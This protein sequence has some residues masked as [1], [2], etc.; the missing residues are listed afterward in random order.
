MDEKYSMRDST[1][2]TSKATP[3]ILFACHEVRTTPCAR[4]PL[5]NS[6]RGHCNKLAV[7]FASS[8]FFRFRISTA[9]QNTKTDSGD[10]SS[11]SEILRHAIGPRHRNPGFG[12]DTTAGKRFVKRDDGHIVLLLCEQCRYDRSVAVRHIAK[13]P[14]NKQESKTIDSISTKQQHNRINKHSQRRVVSS[15]Q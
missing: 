14:I 11:H 3:C 10:A 12:K 7:R 4:S 15:Q 1:R 2:D 6:D 9:N 13:P 5:Q 8:Y